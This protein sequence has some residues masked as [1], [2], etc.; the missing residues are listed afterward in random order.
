MD[1]ET[2]KVQCES[3]GEKFMQY[4]TVSLD[5]IDKAGKSTLVQYLA[6][7]SNF[8]LNILDRGPITNIVWNKMQGRKIVYDVDMW[9]KTLFVRLT[10]DREDWEI[11]CKMHNEPKINFDQHTA[12]YDNVFEM[13]RQQGYHVL[14]FNTTQL[15]QYQ[16]AKKIIEKLNELNA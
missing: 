1:V 4:Y 14:E 13:F 7:L 3:C 5:G 16:I 12:E 15:T 8:T 9:K 2:I 6:R 10:V 11:R